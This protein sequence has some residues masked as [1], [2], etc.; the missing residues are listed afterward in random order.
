VDRIE[1]EYRGRTRQSAARALAAAA[2]MPG[3]DT[4]A[5]AHHAPYPLTVARGEGPF[6]WD[7]DGHR[8]ID[9][10]GNYTSLVH[11]NAYPP[12][13]AALRAAS[14]LGTAWAARC[15]AQI[16]LAEVLVQRVASVEQVRFTNS[17]TEA[18]ML[19]MHI[20]RAATGRRK[21]LMARH[22]YHGSHEDT[23]I[24]LLGV[25]GHNTYLGEFGDAASFERVL[26]EHGNEIACVLLEPVMGSA[27][28]VTAPP[29]FLPHVCSAAQAAGALFVLDEV[30]SFRL[31]TGGAQ[32][33][34]AV[35]PDLTL[36]GK[37]IGGGLPV[38]AVGG[39]RDLLAL[40][41]PGR[42]MMFV[43]GTFNGNPV[44]TAAGV[45]AVHELTAMRIDHMECLATR[46]RGGLLAAAAACGLPCSVTHA[47]SLLNVFFTP[48]PPAATIVRSDYERICRFHLAA[49]NRGLFFAPRG[50][51]ALSTGMTEALIDE[52][53]ER[54]RAAMADVAAEERAGSE[55]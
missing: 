52:V 33:Q 19:A 14:A 44:T 7:V 45:V 28:I 5:A 1:A 25:G 6:L 2:V 15:D 48:E 12:V 34:Y 46:L 21:I 17:G 55:S 16:E 49:L 10:L 8:Y 22:G 43:S 51:M 30:I 27:G 53:I 40:T 41:D 50:M 42:G 47:G 23:E 29:G 9:L 4:R 13:V 38:G 18:T 39:R 26:S 37:L 3:G 36:F 31:A 32:A 24:G 54:A 35:S 11:G 20:A